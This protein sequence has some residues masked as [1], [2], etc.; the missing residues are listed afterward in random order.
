MNNNN[1]LILELCCFAKPRFL[2]YVRR[3]R[4]SSLR[5]FWSRSA[6][7]RR[8]PNPEQSSWHKKTRPTS[9]EA[10][11]TSTRYEM[12]IIICIRILKH[13]LLLFLCTVNVI[14]VRVNRI[15]ES[16]NPRRQTTTKRRSLLSYIRIYI[17]F[18]IIQIEKK[19]FDDKLIKRV[20][21]CNL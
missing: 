2:Y 20:R 16:V 3:S 18:V 13:H 9:T 7:T 8:I 1:C 14:V 21:Y 10:S 4:W 6:P 11:K 17:M 5:C 15:L 12:F 19:Y